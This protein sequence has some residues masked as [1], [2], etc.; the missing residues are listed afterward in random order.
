MAVGPPASSVKATRCKP[1]R[2]SPDTAAGALIWRRASP[3]EP[4]DF[5]T[6][7]R[8]THTLPPHPLPKPPPP[9]PE[10]PIPFDAPPPTAAP[11]RRQLLRQGVATLGVLAVPAI[12]R[13]RSAA[14]I[15]IGYWPVA[16]GLPF[17]AA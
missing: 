10:N 15:R 3:P 5:A 13:A 11:R 9:P 14:R 7:H 6:P 4:Q 2:T 16:A 12:V 17:Y 1:R 8:K